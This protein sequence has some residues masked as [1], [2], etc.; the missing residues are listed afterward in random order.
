[1]LVD[2]RERNI[3]PMAQWEE[4]QSHTMKKHNMVA[5]FEV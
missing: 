2:S 4:Y 5:V 3:D 1:M